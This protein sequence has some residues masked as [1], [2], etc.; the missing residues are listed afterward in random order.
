MKRK[1][2]FYTIAVFLIVFYMLIGIMP[3][4]AN[5]DEWSSLTVTLGTENSIVSIVSVDEY[6]IEA[7]KFDG[8]GMVWLRVSKNGL[9]LGDTVLENNSS[10]WCYMDNNN[11]RLKA[12][13]VTNMENLPMFSNL[14]SPEAEVVF[15]A[16]KSADETSTEDNVSLALDLEAD[17]D[18]YLLSDE[19]IVDTEIRNIGNIKA[20]KVKF[21]VDPDGL[22]VQDGGPEN[23]TIDKGSKKSFELRLRFPERIKDN[24]SITGN[25][26]WEDNS[27]KHFLSKVVDISVSEPLKIYKY[28]GS[29]VFIGTPAYVTVSVKN[30]QDRPVNISLIDPVPATFTMINNSELASSVLGLDNLSYLSQDF[31]LAPEEMKTIS[32]SIKSEKLGAHRVPQT[33]AYANLCGQLYN[34]CSDSEDI[35]T[36]YDNISYKEYNHETQVEEISPV[37]TKLSVNLVP[38]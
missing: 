11:I 14:C 17:K 21:N 27:G 24:Y 38:A 9:T 7:L 20:D 16:K 36:V 15:E 10:S 22:L 28:T 1:G 2:N 5:E 12:C 3:A 13:N 37:K 34:E 18:E 8:Y 32:Y 33:H 31:V 26:S 30:V 23:I 35:I 29:E 19:V 6:T 25:V 4:A